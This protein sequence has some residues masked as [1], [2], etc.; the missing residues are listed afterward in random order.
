VAI[1]VVLEAQ[2][3]AVAAAPP[4]VA[5]VPITNPLPVTVTAVPPPSG[6]PLGLSALTVGTGS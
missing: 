1:Q 5:V 3:T 6:P 4:K 2:L